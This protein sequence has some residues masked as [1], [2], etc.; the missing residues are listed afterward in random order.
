MVHGACSD[1]GFAMALPNDDDS[2]AFAWL[3]LFYQ[4][5]MISICPLI[6]HSRRVI[7]GL[8]LILATVPV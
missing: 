7:D 1:I 6:K 5:V 8:F 4:A 2:E 3:M